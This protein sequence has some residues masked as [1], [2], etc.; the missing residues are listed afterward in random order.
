MPFP[1]Q[2]LIAPLGF[3]HLGD[4]LPISLGIGF[5]PWADLTFLLCPYISHEEAYL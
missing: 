2:H 4:G 5:R 1:E 3:M